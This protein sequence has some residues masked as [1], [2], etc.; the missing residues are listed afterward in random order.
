MIEEPQVPKARQAIQVPPSA[1][2]SVRIIRSNCDQTGCRVQCGESEMLLTA[3]CGPKRN[4]AI[5]PTERAATCRAAG[6]GNSPRLAVCAR[7]EP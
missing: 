7:I 3:Y 4:T 2:S 5:M 6:P 1:V